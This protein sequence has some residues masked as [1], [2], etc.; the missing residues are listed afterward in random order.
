LIKKL[1]NLEHHNLFFDEDF[2]QHASEIYEDP[3]WPENPAIYVSRNTVTDPGVAPDGQDNLII[4]IPTAQ[5]WKIVTKFGNT[6]L[7]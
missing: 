7:N 2:T 3:K 5:D 1:K 6:I 4:L